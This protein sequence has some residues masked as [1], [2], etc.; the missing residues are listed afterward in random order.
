MDGIVLECYIR[1]LK[2]VLKVSEWPEQSLHT[3][4][5]NVYH[6]H[7]SL[8]VVTGSFEV[9]IITSCCSS[10]EGTPL[11]DIVSFLMISSGIT[12]WMEE[13]IFSNKVINRGEGSNCTK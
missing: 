6:P 9:V 10:C 13:P 5:P 4:H 8:G 11:V 7:N 2:K 3:A 12:S 1:T